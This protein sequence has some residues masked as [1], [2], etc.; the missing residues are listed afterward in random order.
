MKKVLV[1]LVIVTFMV[2]HTVQLHA[3]TE[4]AAAG[5]TAVTAGITT[6]T[7]VTGVILAAAVAAAI[8]ASGGGVSDEYI[9]TKTAEQQA[10]ENLQKNT[11]TTT[12][13]A[14]SQTALTLNSQ[15]LTN[16]A[17]SSGSVLAKSY[18][19]VKLSEALSGVTVA[20][21]NALL[22]NPASNL[23]KYLSGLQAADPA[24]YTAFKATLD[25][26]VARGS[27]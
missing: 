13:S 11:S 1:F 7:I 16:L 25:S 2:F 26:I 12:Q 10:T 23:S 9:P 24:A 27:N 20:N 19:N 4:A 17:Q 5:A 18:N 14:T 22:S 21:Y 8:A 6:G 3:Q 15:E